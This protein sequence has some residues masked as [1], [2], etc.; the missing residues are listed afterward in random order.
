[1]TALVNKNWYYEEL[2]NHQAWIADRLAK[3]HELIE[4]LGKEY[5][6]VRISELKEMKNLVEI[7]M[8]FI[9]FIP[10]NVKEIT[11]TTE[12]YDKLFLN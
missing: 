8:T 4:D 1:M 7:E 6:N 5:A 12:E 11:I 9:E 3:K 10:E 2:S